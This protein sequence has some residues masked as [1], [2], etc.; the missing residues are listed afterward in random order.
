MASQSLNQ[1][2]GEAQATFLPRDILPGSGWAIDR[3]PAES[4]PC[5]VESAQAENGEQSSC[6]RGFLVAIA[7]EGVVGLVVFALW[8]AWHPMI[9]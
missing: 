7:I 5:I 9:R 3:A 6:I 2:K 1:F 8:Q 4:F